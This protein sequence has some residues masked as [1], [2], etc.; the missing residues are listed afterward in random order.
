MLLQVGKDDDK[1]IPTDKEW[2]T[3]PPCESLFFKYTEKV[4]ESLSLIYNGQFK[5]LL[6]GELPD[7]KE[8]LQSLLN[9]G[10]RLKGIKWTI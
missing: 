6:T 1:A 2:L 10:S 7:E 8:L 4:W 3:K 5:E 9:I